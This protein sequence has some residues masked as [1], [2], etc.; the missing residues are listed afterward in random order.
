MCHISAIVN[1][2]YHEHAAPS[3]YGV[4]MPGQTKTTGMT[5][6][7]PVVLRTFLLVLTSVY[8]GFRKYDLGG[9]KSLDL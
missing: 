4:A 6:D 8:Y 9:R 1:T 7:M 2:F 3:A 5:Y